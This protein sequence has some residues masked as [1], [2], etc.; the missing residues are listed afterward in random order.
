MLGAVVMVTT[1]KR[2]AIRTLFH[3]GPQ[4]MALDLSNDG[5]LLAI[6]TMPRCSGQPSVQ[7][8][9]TR[10]RQVVAEFGKQDYLARGVAF[11][12]VTRL[13]T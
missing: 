10:D 2:W 13:G 6:A 5:A 8:V 1:R 4:V 11:C 9:R 3:N 12:A 7:V